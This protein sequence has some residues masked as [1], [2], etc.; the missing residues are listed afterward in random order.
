MRTSVGQSPRD[1]ARIALEIIPWRARL[2]GNTSRRRIMTGVRF[3]A[4]RAGAIV[5]I[6]LLLSACSA[7]EQFE[8]KEAAVTIDG[9]AIPFEAFRKRAE[10][11]FA[12]L[13]DEEAGESKVDEE[14]W[15]A[16]F[17]QYLDGQLLIRLAI[18]RGLVDGEVDEKRAI[19]YLL[20]ETGAEPS[21]QEIETYYRANRKKFER[22]ERVHLRQILVDD[23]DLARQAQEAL[24]EG[25][26]FADVTARLSQ[27]PTAHLG[28]DQ[29]ILARDDLPAK[30]VD[31]IFSLE[32]G[33]VS[34]IV[35]SDFGFQIFQ[36]EKRL[37]AEVIPLEDAL[38]LI[39]EELHRRSVDEQVASRLAEARER[40][41]L[42]LYP[43]HIPF[44]YRGLYASHQAE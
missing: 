30:L 39:R 15:S 25:E 9:E 37:A 2:D 5:G 19:Q 22:P 12:D 4:A 20:R 17:D 7:V 28:G 18:E 33:E 26:D 34:G 31:L 36:V 21:R 44:D 35:E 1:K 13:A 16:L 8:R 41:D 3:F 40:Y 14:V 27:G 23:R 42:I 11:N 6:L 43:K 32:P 24:N 29:G 10:I 38:P